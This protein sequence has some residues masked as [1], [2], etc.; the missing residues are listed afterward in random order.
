MY[1]PASDFPELSP[2]RAKGTELNVVKLREIKA[3]KTKATGVIGKK[4][5]RMKQ[6]VAIN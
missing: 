3:I 6:A 1:N 2:K 5:N 4:I